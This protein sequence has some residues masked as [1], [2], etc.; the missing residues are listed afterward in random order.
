MVAV[1][2]GSG[3]ATAAKENEPLT[4]DPAA[5][6]AQEAVGFA[7]LVTTLVVTTVEVRPLESV[8]WA[9]KV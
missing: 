3:S 8:A 2:L 7:L 9:V 1:P 5:G 4:V 6:L